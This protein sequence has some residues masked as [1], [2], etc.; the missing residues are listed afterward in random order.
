VVA[1]KEL[2]KQTELILTKEAW[3]IKGIIYF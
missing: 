3:L 1:A 2:N